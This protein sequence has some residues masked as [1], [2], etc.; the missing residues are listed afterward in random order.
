M[1]KVGRFLGLTSPILALG[2]AALMLFGSSYSYQSGDSEGNFSSGAISAFRYTLEE[3]DYAWFFWAGFVVIVCLIAAVGALIGRAG[4]V[5]A[6][7]IVLYLVAVLGMVSIIGVFIF[8][9]AMVL[10]VSAVLLT[11]ARHGTENV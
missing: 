5:W 10:F 9:L 11:V 8:P 7:A 3:G 4:P 1:S 2:I 6:A